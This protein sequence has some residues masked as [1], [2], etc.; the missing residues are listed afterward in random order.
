MKLIPFNI[1][2]SLPFAALVTFSLACGGEAPSSFLRGRVPMQATSVELFSLDAQGTGEA[3]LIAKADV[4]VDG[5]FEL[6]AQPSQKKLICRALDAS[7]KL[8][9]SVLVEA[10]AKVDE[11]LTLTPMSAE[12]TLEAKVVTELVASG[13][14]LADIN[15]VDVRA[16]VSAEAA[17]AAGATA[18][19]SAELEAKVQSLA[20]ATSAALD[21]TIDTY[22][23]AGITVDH[24]ALMTSQLSA[25]D[26][27]NSELDVS[28]DA[29]RAE[30]TFLSKLAAEVAGSITATQRAKAEIAA[31]A[32]F[33][34]ELQKHEVAVGSA[35]VEASLKSS[36]K[37]EA[38]ATRIAT[39][40]ILRA[41]GASEATVAA[42]VEASEK[43]AAQLETTTSVASSGEAYAQFEAEVSAAT[44]ACVQTGEL[45]AEASAEVKAAL[46]ALASLDVP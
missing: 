21:M 5:R 42:A 15:F 6:S 45:T 3:T 43:L 12:T 28:T 26:T 27:L 44:D 29:K 14:S 19:A 20:K 17:V 24:D 18:G 31:S 40:A 41:S 4:S 11:Q 13:R 23:K 7:G 33:R 9:A 32:A 37:L 22:A 2:S 16:R 36:A 34:A 30:L 25:V 38:E 46:D 8:V 39:E 35:F 10:T 1:R